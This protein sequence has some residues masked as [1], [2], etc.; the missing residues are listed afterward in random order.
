MPKSLIKSGLNLTASTTA[1]SMTLTHSSRLSASKPQRNNCAEREQN[2]HYCHYNGLSAL[3]SP[4]AAKKQPAAMNPAQ[5][6]ANPARGPS[7]MKAQ[8][9]PSTAT[10]TDSASNSVMASPI[11]SVLWDSALT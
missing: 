10:L 5:T 11:D 8:I 6:R 3:V 9:P 7:A 4:P 2:P 1:S